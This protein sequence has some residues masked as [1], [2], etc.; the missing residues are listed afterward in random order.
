MKNSIEN[1]LKWFKEFQK[2]WSL[3]RVEEMTLEQYT[4]LTETNS[5]RTDFTYWID[6]KLDKEAEFSTVGQHASKAFEIYRTNNQPKRKLKMILENGYARLDKYHSNEDAFESVKKRILQVI[7]AS[8]QN[9]LNTIDKIELDNTFKWKIAFHY[10]K[11]LDDMKIINIASQSKL[12]EIRE[13]EQLG[14]GDLSMSEIYRLILGDKKYNFEEIIQKTE[15]LWKKYDN[16]PQNKSNKVNED[17]NNKSSTKI[18]LNQILYGPPGTG[19]TYNT[20]NKALEILVNEKYEDSF[21]LVKEKLNAEKN[22]EIQS[23]KEILEK[24]KSNKEKDRKKLKA[25]FDAFKDN[26]QIAFVTFHQSYGYEEFVEGI[27]PDLD[28]K[29]TESKDISYK[30]HD[31]IFKQM[32]KEALEN[33]KKPYIIIIDEINRGNISK[34]L[35]ELITLIEPSKRIGAKEELR[36]ELPYSNES[37]GVPENL[38]IIGTMN[39]ADRSIALLD[40][41]LRRRF[42]FIE[43]MPKPEKLGKCG[44]TNLN[45]LLTAMNNRIEFLLDREHT[46]GHSYFIDVNNYEKLCDVFKNK[47]IPLLQEYFYDDYAKRLSLC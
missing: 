25:I 6:K 4:S 9:D 32:C 5:E 45:T 13:S 40:T 36:V 29:N 10:Q 1:K 18:P 24:I 27:K 15:V 37:F 35:G 30:I 8:Q 11:N 47:I 20:I 28:S 43:M 38:Y 46:I 19:K 7:K 16:K 33:P 26:G 14:N 12:K 23:C 3:E 31:G 41:A 42:D 21:E 22:L 39:T 44:D 2:E 34:I 17:N